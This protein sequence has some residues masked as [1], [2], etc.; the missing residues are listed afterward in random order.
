MMLELVPKDRAVIKHLMDQMKKGAY[1]GGRG[2][3]RLVIFS[4][5]EGFTVIDGL[6]RARF[7]SPLLMG[8][9]IARED[10][11]AARIRE[12]ELRTAFIMKLF[13]RCHARTTNVC[14]TERE[15]E[16][17]SSSKL[18]DLKCYTG[19]TN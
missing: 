7:E 16:V 18:F 15:K 6:D 2:C 14:Q 9:T 10:A 17:R 13:R 8:S 5:S 12:K 4:V 11:A 1:G 3:V 19:K